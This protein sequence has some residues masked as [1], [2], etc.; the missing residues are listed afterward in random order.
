MAGELISHPGEAT[1]ERDDDPEPLGGDPSQY[2]MLAIPGDIRLELI[3]PV[4]S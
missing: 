4:Q 3:A 1:L 2:M